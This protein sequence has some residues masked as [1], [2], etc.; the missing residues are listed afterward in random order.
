MRETRFGKLV[1][2]A[3]NLVDKSLAPCS[4][5]CRVVES[6]IQLVSYSQSVRVNVVCWSG[7]ADPRA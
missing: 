1:Y 3:F 4:N 6:S 5:A 2:R 7:V